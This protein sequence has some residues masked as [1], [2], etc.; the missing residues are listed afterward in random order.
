[1]GSIY[2]KLQD[3]SLRFASQCQS[4][5]GDVHVRVNNLLS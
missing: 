4:Y 2:G 1:M 3:T 5:D